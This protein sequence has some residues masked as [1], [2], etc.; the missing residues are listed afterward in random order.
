MF[1]LFFSA[2]YIHIL[3]LTNLKNDDFRTICEFFLKYDPMQKWKCIIRLQS[4]AFYKLNINL[5]NTQ[6]KKALSKASPL[7]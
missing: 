7:P 6:I 2:H 5:V 1:F 3:E 4:D